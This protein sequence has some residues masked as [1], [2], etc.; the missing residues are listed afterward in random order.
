[1]PTYT[2]VVRPDEVDELLVFQPIV[3]AYCRMWQCF[4]PNCEANNA[5]TEVE[6]EVVLKSLT[7]QYDVSSDEAK[8]SSPEA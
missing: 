7:N 1:M 6:K 4:F 3:R 2:G 8:I 5:D